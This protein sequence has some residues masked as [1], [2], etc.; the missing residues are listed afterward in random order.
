MYTVVRGGNKKQQ[1]FLSHS[2]QVEQSSR[3]TTY[4]SYIN[5]K[6]VSHISDEAIHMDPKVTRKQKENPAL[7]TSTMQTLRKKTSALKWLKLT[8]LPSH[9]P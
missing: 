1:R 4:L 9:L 6:S 7:A 5:H 3:Q 8:F 2:P